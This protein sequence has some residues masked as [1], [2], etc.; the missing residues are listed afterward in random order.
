MRRRATWIPADTVDA[1]I[2]SL[3]AG[4]ENDA[5]AGSGKSEAMFIVI[6]IVVVFGSIIAGYLME[7]GNLRVLIQPAELIIIGGAAIGT[8]LI[9]NPLQVIKK[10]A[11]GVM[12]IGER[13]ALQQSVLS[14]N[15]EDV[16]RSSEQGTERRT[17]GD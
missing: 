12:G 11:G 9:A 15:A 5:A 7:H 3:E 4:L 2:Q 8:L 10:I 6:G 16:L 17:A 13:F 1:L 14:G